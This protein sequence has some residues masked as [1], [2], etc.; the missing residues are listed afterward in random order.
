[1][2]ASLCEEKVYAVFD[3]IPGRLSK[4]EKKYRLSSINRNARFRAYGDPLCKNG[5]PL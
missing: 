4:K 1:M 2:M 3:G 5:D